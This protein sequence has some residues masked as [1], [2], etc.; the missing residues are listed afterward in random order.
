MGLLC[1][2]LDAFD[3]MLFDVEE[4]MIEGTGARQPDRSVGTVAN[5]CGTAL[6]SATWVQ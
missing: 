6:A 2:T 4:A 5:S 1:E 3:E